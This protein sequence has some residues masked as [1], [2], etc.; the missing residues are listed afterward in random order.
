MR[1]PG[2]MHLCAIFCNSLA[3]ASMVSTVLGWNTRL[4]RACFHPVTCLRVATAQLLVS[5]NG[6]QSS[7]L[8]NLE[9]KKNCSLGLNNSQVS[10]QHQVTLWLL[11]L[12]QKTS[13]VGLYVSFL[14]KKISSKQSKSGSS[15]DICTL[16]SL[17]Q[18]SHGWT[19]RI[20]GSVKYANHRRMNTARFWLHEAPKTITH[21]HRTGWWLPGAEGRRK[22]EVFAQCVWSFRCA[23]RVSSR[24]MLHNRVPTGSNTISRTLKYIRKINFIVGFLN[25][26][27]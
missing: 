27:T 7:L 17:Q 15:R 18:N 2:E 22:W 13:K 26:H 11:N 1:P 10:E 23:R 20:L 4:A 8:G 16:C 9:N 3:E 24:D 14:R 5:E 6:P 19:Q 25:T 12:E 21:R